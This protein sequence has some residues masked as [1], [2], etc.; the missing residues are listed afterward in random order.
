MQSAVT[1][2]TRLKCSFR[3]LEELSAMDI[4]ALQKHYASFVTVA[5]DMEVEGSI[6][7]EE[8]EKDN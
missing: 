1:R 3:A 4:E 5:G 8:K 7:S 2:V 6:R